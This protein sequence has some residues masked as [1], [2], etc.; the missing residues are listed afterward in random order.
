M[1]CLGTHVCGSAL[2]SDD[3]GCDEKQTYTIMKSE[4]NLLMIDVFG[5]NEY[6]LEGLTI[7]PVLTSLMKISYNVGSRILSNS[8]GTSTCEYTHYSMEMDRFVYLNDDYVILV[9]AGNEGPESFTIGAPATLK[10]GISVGA[11]QNN[12]E[13]S[14][15]S[16]SA[17]WDKLIELFP[18]YHL[19]GYGKDN[20]ASFSS[21]G[22]TCDGRIKPDIVAPGEFIAS[23]RSGTSAGLLW[24][25]GTSQATPITSRMVTIIREYL[26]KTQN[27]PAPSAALIKNILVTSAEHLQGRS[28]HMWIDTVIL[29]LRSLTDKRKLDIY[30]QGHGRISLTRLLNHQLTLAD[31]LIITGYSKPQK[32]CYKSVG[33][34]KASFG[35]VWTDPPGMLHQKQTLVNNLNLQIIIYLNDGNILN[36]LHGNNNIVPDELNNVEKVTVRLSPL[37]IIE[38]VVSTDGPIENEQQLY[39]LVHYGENLVVTE[40]PFECTLFSPPYQCIDTMGRTGEYECVDGHYS[41]SEC[42]INPCRNIPCL[43]T[44][45]SPGQLRLNY[46]LCI[47]GIPGNKTCETEAVSVYGNRNKAQEHGIRNLWARVVN[48]GEYTAIDTRIWSVITLI[49]CVVIIFAA[50][51]RI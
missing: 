34:I 32:R 8:W 4:S 46:N 43:N 49:S 21:R 37:D 19:E 6:D 2:G 28:Q 5:G 24:M 1:E 25:R 17:W 3:T 14:R 39:T 20:L 45:N 13:S 23:A 30:D 41:L 27:L 51:L 16:S 44:T 15:S 48:S 40:C 22:P 38:V 12:F 29:K 9:A 31:R 33:S 35:L 26:I 42:V 11:S 7:P 18:S 10:N 36:V 47:N 50:F